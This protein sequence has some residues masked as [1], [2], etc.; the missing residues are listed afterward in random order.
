VN[1]REVGGRQCHGCLE[2][3][4]IALVMGRERRRH[5]H[6]M[7]GKGGGGDSASVLHGA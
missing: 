6:L 2:T 3:R 5:C 4:A 7:E 1:G